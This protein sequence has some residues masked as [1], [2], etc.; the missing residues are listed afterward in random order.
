[1]ADRANVSDAVVVTGAYARKCLA[2]V[3]SL[4]MRGCEVS[5][6]NVDRFGPPM[7]SRWAAHRF[8]YRDPGAAPEAFLSDVDREA[9]VRGASLIFPTGGGDTML[10]AKERARFDVPV[11]APSIASIELANDKEALLRAAEAAGVPIPRTYF[12]ARGRIPEIR[13]EARFPILVRPNRGSGGRGLIRV[14]SADA[15]EPAIEKVFAAFGS[16]LV[17]EFVPSR[18]K[19]FGC[20]GVM[21]LR[22]RPV[23]L[24]C[25]RRLREYPIGGG[26]ATFV[27]SIDA[28]RLAA[29]AEK[30][31]VALRWTSVAMTEWRLDDRDGVFK[32]IEINPRMWGSSHLAI[33]AGVDIPWLLHEV[34]LGRDVERVTRYEPGVRRRWLLPA[35]LLHWMKSPDRKTMDP[36]FWRMFERRTRYDFMDPHDLGPAIANVVWLAREVL[37]GRAKNHVERGA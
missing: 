36:P 32:L 1:M 14:E 27:E 16:V 13:R 15:L 29:Q 28:P 21:D 3:T 24:F 10:L 30:L 9:R 18:L 35:D 20:S 37:Q 7:W 25:H 6:G 12:E 34:H 2:V 4:G 5:A 19:G 17:Q 11:V 8:L 23:A 22:S 33:D 31:L 26:P